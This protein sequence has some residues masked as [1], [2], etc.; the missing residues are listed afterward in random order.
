MQYNIIIVLYEMIIR[1]IDC[2]VEIINDIHVGMYA[3]SAHVL[4]IVT[5]YVQYYNTCK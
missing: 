4:C 2:E 1:I 3:N 5:A